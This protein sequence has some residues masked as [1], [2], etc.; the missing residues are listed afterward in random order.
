VGLVARVIETDFQ[1]PQNSPIDTKSTELTLLVNS[2]YTGGN[3]GSLTALN[4]V[5]GGGLLNSTGDT[6]YYSDVSGIVTFYV[7]FVLNDFSSAYNRKNIFLQAQLF[8]LDNQNLGMTEFDITARCN[9][10]L[11]SLDISNWVSLLTLL[12]QTKA[13]YIKVKIRGSYVTGGEF[14]PEQFSTTEFSASTNYYS[15]QTQFFTIPCQKLEFDNRQHFYAI[16]DS[17]VGGKS[18][19]LFQWYAPAR[20]PEVTQVRNNLKLANFVARSMEYCN[21]TYKYMDMGKIRRITG[22]DL[23]SSFKENGIYESESVQRIDEFGV[24]TSW[25]VEDRT[26]GISSEDLYPDF[27][28]RLSRPVFGNTINSPNA[29]P[30]IKSI[31]ALTTSAVF[32]CAL[33][34]Y[35]TQVPTA[36]GIIINNVKYRSFTPSNEYSVAVTGLAPETQYSAQAYIETNLG[37]VLGQP[38]IFTTQ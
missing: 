9:I 27:E 5:N 8:D 37:E 30:Y 21:L 31:K 29:V 11:N 19:A 26:Y 3:Y 32:D 12:D 14:E 23:G 25:L 6:L 7:N 18:S 24:T 1:S 15:T 20:E 34:Q 28:I 38:Q 22:F 17:G 13:A 10:G 36:K 35:G 4:P 16:Y 33:A 2:S